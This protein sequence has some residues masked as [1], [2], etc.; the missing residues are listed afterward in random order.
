MNRVRRADVY[1][2]M[3]HTTS[4]RTRWSRLALLLG[5]ALALTLVLGACSS[6]KSSSSSADITVR[7][8]TF[9]SVPVKAG[10]TVTVHNDGPST[11]T[12]TADN[13]S[14]NVSIDAGKDATFTAPAKAG[15][16][17]FHC[18]IHSQMHGTLTVT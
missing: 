18:S 10:A 2:G 4:P 1:V 6:S 12:V 9:T 14:F 15:T 7:D 3:H 5:V 11:H 8:F 13:G 17:K 16:Y